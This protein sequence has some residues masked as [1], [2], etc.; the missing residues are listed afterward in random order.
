MSNKKKSQ[1]IEFTDIQGLGAVSAG[2]LVSHSV[3]GDGEVLALAQWESGEITVNVNF[4]KYGSKW[5]DTKYTDLS[6]QQP[7][8]EPTPKANIFQRLF[9]RKETK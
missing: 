3:F 6:E 5:L 7:S 9:G 8:P 1:P 4:E 2:S